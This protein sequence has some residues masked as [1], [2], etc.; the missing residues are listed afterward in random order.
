M[1]GQRSIE[2]SIGVEAEQ[3]VVM[4]SGV[5]ES[6]AAGELAALF[7]DVHLRASAR[8]GRVIVDIRRLEFATSSCLRAYANWIVA[9]SAAGTYR[10]RFLS[11]PKHS[12]QR[13]SLTAL[14]GITEGLV[15][16]GTSA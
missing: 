15:E 16:I 1:A 11:E 9:A 5:A 13:R 6:S 2:V 14:A 8:P 12:W 4:I 3:L 7:D 10:I